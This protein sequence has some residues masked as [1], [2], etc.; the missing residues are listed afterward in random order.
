M[1][2]RDESVDLDDAVA[3][4]RPLIR[5]FASLR[6]AL[7]GTHRD[8]TVGSIPRAIFLLAV[9]MVV[10]MAMESL[11]AVVDIFWVGRLGQPEAVAVVGLTES[12]LALVYALA[13]GLSMAAMATVARRV[14]EKDPEG[15]ARF[16]VQ[17]IALGLLVA[18]PLGIAGGYFSRD[19]LKL[20]GAQ[21]ETIAKCGGYATVML[22][23]NA[24][25]ILL[26]L[27]NAVFR[28]A[29]DAV[30]PMRTLW[31]ANGINLVLDPCFIF[32]VGPFPRLG[33]MGAAVAT[34]TGRA[35]GVLFLIW[36]LARGAR[37]VAVSRRHLALSPARMATILRL[38][39]A[40]I[41]QALVHTTSWLGVVR[42]LADFG[43]KAVAG[44]TIGI[45]IV[46]LALLPSW[47]M[48]NA[49]AT[50]VGQSLGAGKPE[51]AE[52]AVWLAGFYNMIFLGAV[53]LLFVF[54]APLIVRG[55]NDS[56]EVVAHGVECLRTLSYGFL[57]YA[58]G[59]VFVQ[60]FN[61]A[62][63]PWTPTWINVGCFWAW[64]VPLALL[65]AHPLG[66]GPRG[67]F[68]AVAVAFSTFAV[69]GALL[70]RRGRWKTRR[71]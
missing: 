8:Y 40:G 52:Q 33:V 20:M 49:A 57:F 31:L 36:Q 54:G 44:N 17:A 67:V 27:I 4:P 9:P 14:G 25:I 10:E 45:R 34:T 28:G 15:A 65:L 23:G 50:M 35:I 47:G 43:E 1:T 48:S 32:G 59:M 30:I 13:M 3:P 68:I 22:G 51:R 53:G 29:G 7:R 39:G 38:S 19:L 62:G 66:L 70:F 21:P 63:D 5:L 64:Q 71:V 41:V 2:R 24:V 37:H 16:A 42:V 26:F 12:L 58:Y 69:V 61:G 55:F 60:A 6:E 46:L 11:F 18:L 56:P